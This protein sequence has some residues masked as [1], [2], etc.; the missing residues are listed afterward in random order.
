M[1]VHPDLKLCRDGLP[2]E[3]VRR[4]EHPRG[5]DERAAAGV[6][7]PAGAL[8]CEGDLVRE[9]ELHSRLT[10]DDAWRV[11]GS[12]RA[13]EPRNERGGC[14]GRPHCANA[15]RQTSFVTVRL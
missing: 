12:R 9:R 1:I 8:S 15:Q 2:C 6:I 7:E 14:A 5:V 4:R 13:G 10:I 3:A 11:L